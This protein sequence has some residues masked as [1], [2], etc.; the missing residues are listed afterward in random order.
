MGLQLTYC[1]IAFSLFE[2]LARSSLQEA[3]QV[4]SLRSYVTGSSEVFTDGRECDLNRRASCLTN[5]SPL[6]KAPA[7]FVLL[8]FFILCRGNPNFCAVQSVGSAYKIPLKPQLAYFQ[9]V[10]S[11]FGCPR[12][13]WLSTCRKY[14][15]FGRLRRKYIF[16]NFTSQLSYVKRHAAVTKIWGGCWHGIG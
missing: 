13:L 5:Q 16:G 12:V 6:V 3:N 8:G 4:A 9:M 14:L 15:R 7:A 10:I 11:G 1:D 2:K